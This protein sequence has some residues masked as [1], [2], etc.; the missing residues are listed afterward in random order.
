MAGTYA[1]NKAQRSRKSQIE[2]NRTL[3][4]APETTALTTYP[5]TATTFIKMK[6]VKNPQNQNG[7][8]LTGKCLMFNNEATYPE[9]DSVLL[10]SGL[11]TQKKYAR[12]V[13]QSN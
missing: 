8:T 7:L 3:E 9:V 10:V 6:H 4:C 11:P 13:M 1:R 2:T 5:V 12:Q